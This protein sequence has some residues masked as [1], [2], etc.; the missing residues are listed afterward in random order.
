[1]IAIDTSTKKII[2]LI[3]LISVIVF[4]LAVVWNNLNYSFFV[5]LLFEDAEEFA[6][7]STITSRLMPIGY[8]SVVG[9]C[10]RAFGVQGIPACQSVI[11]G[12]LVFLA[13]GFLYLVGV[14]SFY[15]AAGVFAIALHP[16]LLLNVWRI[17]DGNLTILLL[18]G[19]L[20]SGIAYMSRAPQSPLV[21]RWGSAA[22]VLL[23]GIFAGF[24]FTVRI[25][26]AL[27]VLPALFVLWRR[28]RALLA[29]LSVAGIFLGTA[30]LVFIMV[31][32]GVKQ[33]PFFFPAHGWYNF[34]AGNNEYAAEY[35]WKE[36][37]GE[38]SLEKALE[39]R[40][41][42]GVETIEARL[43]F[44]P[45]TYRARAL[46]YIQNNPG[47]YVELG[48]IKLI[49]LLRPGYH[50]PENF[51]WISA[52]GVK[53]ILKTI[54]ATPFFIWAFVL[55]KTRR[56]FFDEENV[57]VFL[58]AALYALPFLAANADPRFRFP[59][60]IVFMADSFR[61][62]ASASGSLF[63]KKFSGKL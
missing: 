15:L 49:T 54:L 59:L 26:T 5:N 42:S 22:C 57:F 55:Y 31:N 34:F 4:A 62:A 47:E 60:D 19:F 36:Y 39:A 25:N 11:Y 63:Y 33:T 8:S 30:T 1:M 29:R 43:A 53:R 23:L 7:T 40:G 46:H 21:A 18:L 48:A 37:T 56:R 10:I 45:E 41:Y 16:V 3:G 51:V 38:N 52:E 6:H 20:A 50:M 32:L 44:P 35:L 27:L 28:E 24:L 12:A 13:I 14:R 58:A 2:L 9:L 17:H 61:R